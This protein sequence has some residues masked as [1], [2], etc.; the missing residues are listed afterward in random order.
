M[1]G[2]LRLMD[3]NLLA[4]LA[5]FVRDRLLLSDG[6]AEATLEARLLNLQTAVLNMQPVLESLLVPLGALD[7]LAIYGSTVGAYAFKSLF[8]Q[9]NGPQIKVRRST[10]NVEADLW[11]HANGTLYKLQTSTETLMHAQINFA[12]WQGASTKTS[13]KVI[14]CGAIC[15]RA[16]G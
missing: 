13:D 2:M 8:L 5:T 16:F 15:N 10:D 9:Y 3:V 7:S 6:V 4:R 12:A 1:A 14:I 11:Y